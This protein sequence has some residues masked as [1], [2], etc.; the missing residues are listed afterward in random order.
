MK[1]ENTHDHNRF[2]CA[3]CRGRGYLIHGCEKI[4]C[5]CG[6][7]FAGVTV[8]GP[9]AAILKEKMENPAQGATAYIGQGIYQSKPTYVFSEEQFAALCKAAGVEYV[10]P[11][12]YD[13][14]LGWMK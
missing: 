8:Q 4:P 6:A 9:V 7:T 5:T 12:T 13:S 10:S 3:N 2:L 11:G 14:E 1:Q